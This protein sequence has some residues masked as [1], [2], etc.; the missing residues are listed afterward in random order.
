MSIRNLAVMALASS[1]LLAGIAGAAEEK[2]QI[3]T[4]M[5]MAGMPF[6]MPAQTTTVCLPPGQ[7]SNEKMVPADRK[8]TVSGMKTSG[9]TT[10]FHVECPPPDKMSGDGE[11]TRQGPDA[12]SG[13]MAMSGV[14][15]GERMDM[16]MSYSGKKL[17]LCDP[18]KDKASS[19]AAMMQQQQATMAAS[20]ADLAKD[21]SWQVA[22]QMTTMCPTVKADICRNAKKMLEA[23]K[24]SDKV[25]DM[26]DERQDWQG[27]A[28]Y[29]GMDAAALSAKYCAL[30]KKEQNWNNASLICGEDAELEAVAKRECTGKMYSGAKLDEKWKSLCA[31]YADRVDPG[32]APPRSAGQKAADTG[33]RAVEGVMKLKGLFGH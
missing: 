4:K 30:A 5:E 21:M 2:W 9:N 11:F 24:S 27:L 23:P 17:G 25:L 33:K 16:K 14:S 1:A 26:Q 18:V 10:R 32:E 22:P 20:C 6:A 3:T 29:C 31:R 15:D 8:C 12:Y 19:P 7:Q 13:T 28:G